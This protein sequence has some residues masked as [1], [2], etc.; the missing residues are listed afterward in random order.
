[1]T[2]PAENPT[3]SSTDDLDD[4]IAYLAGRISLDEYGR[5]LRKK[6]HVPE[7][8]D[9]IEDVVL[10]DIFYES[11]TRL[12]GTLQSLI[13]QA[14]ESGDAQSEEHWRQEQLKVKKD[15]SHVGADNRDGQIVAMLRWNRRDAELYV[16]SGK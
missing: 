15:R 11:A 4:Q 16:K 2:N 8:W 6:W 1:M 7:R 5:R 12:C 13:Y 9:S 3:A 10:Y 14:R